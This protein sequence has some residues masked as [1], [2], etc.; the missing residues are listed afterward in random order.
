MRPANPG[1]RE[2]AAGLTQV[3]VA[4][5]QMDQMILQSAA[6]VEHTTAAAQAMRN[7]AG[8]LSG[9]IVRFRVS[10]AGDAAPHQVRAA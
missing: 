9:E 6:M 1:A 2:Q 8:R 7:S 3:N 4:I 5:K 10:A